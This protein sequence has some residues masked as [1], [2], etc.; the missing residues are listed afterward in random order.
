MNDYVALF[1][2]EEKKYIDDKCT[3]DRL[4]LYANT[5]LYFICQKY[6]DTICDRMDTL[7][8][9]ENLN[10]YGRQLTEL[11]WKNAKYEASYLQDLKNTTY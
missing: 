10:K 3:D 8:K 5:I 9:D 6:M 7:K 4:R 1:E 2:K 11:A